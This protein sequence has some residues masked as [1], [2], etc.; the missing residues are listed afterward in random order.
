M[1]KSSERPGFSLEEFQK[2]EY[3]V[4]RSRFL[5]SNLEEEYKQYEA[6]INDKAKMDRVLKNRYSIDETK[7]MSPMHVE[8]RDRSKSVV[9]LPAI[10]SA[11]ESPVRDYSPRKDDTTKAQLAK[12]DKLKNFIDN[13]ISKIYSKKSNPL[14]AP[15][16]KRGLLIDKHLR[17][18]QFLENTLGYLEKCTKTKD[19]R[20]AI[21]INHLKKKFQD[22]YE[23][24]QEKL[25]QQEKERNELGPDEQEE[26]LFTEKFY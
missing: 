6:A 22:E 1:L 7:D 26:K 20:L 5:V 21:D 16:P 17:N 25:L 11:S 8:R 14:P 12:M 24:N 4:Y 3:L 18:K 15:D 13:C 10:A 19:Q 9:K 23:E 2:L